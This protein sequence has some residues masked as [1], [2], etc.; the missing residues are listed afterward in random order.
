MNTS[1][2]IYLKTAENKLDIFRLFFLCK[3]FNKIDFFI[4]KNLPDFIKINPKQE[5]PALFID[6]NLLV[7][8]VNILKNK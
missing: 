3:K 6:D 8:S 7:Q 1:Q 4:F 2:L 5:V